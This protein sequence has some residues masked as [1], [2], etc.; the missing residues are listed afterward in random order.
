MAKTLTCL[1]KTWQVTCGTIL[2]CRVHHW[3]GLPR[4]SATS[5]GAMP[6]FHGLSMAATATAVREHRPA[7]YLSRHMGGIW[8]Q[9]FGIWTR[10][11]LPLFRVPQV[12]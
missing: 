10:S 3:T 5:G 9:V 8:R 1:P 2:I 6:L 11:F 7:S 12:G 4:G